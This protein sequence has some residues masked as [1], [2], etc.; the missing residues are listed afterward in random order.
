MTATIIVVSLVL[1]ALFVAVA[2]LGNRA[3]T[4]MAERDRER[5][6]EGSG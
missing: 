5:G 4:R 2:I 1:M 3:Q 6:E